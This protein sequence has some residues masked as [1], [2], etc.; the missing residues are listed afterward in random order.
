M[1]QKLPAQLEDK[2]RRFLEDIRALRIQYK[3]NKSLI[4]NMDKTP[5]CFDMPSSTAADVRGKKDI[6]VRGTGAHKRRFTVTLACTAS[7][8]MLTPFVTF[9][10]KTGIQEDD[11][12]RGR[13]CCY[14][15]AQMM[16]GQ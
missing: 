9:K 1:Q 7:E 2:L 3:F 10:A 11:L 12:Q 5:M 8:T 16:D 6:L 14:Q 4:L 13:H 15:P